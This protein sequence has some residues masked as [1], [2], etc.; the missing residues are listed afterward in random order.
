MVFLRAFLR[1]IVL[2]VIILAIA[3]WTFA[4][5]LQMTLLNRQ[6]VKVWGEQSGAYGKLVDTLE[7]RQVDATG[8]VSG[9]M[10]RQA[11]GTTF[12]PDYVQEQAEM[13]VDATYDWIDGDASQIAYTIPLHERQNDFIENLSQVLKERVQSLPQCS[14]S[15]SM[16]VECIPRAYTVESYARSVAEQ[17]ADDSDLFEEPLTSGDMR[18]VDAV[19][20]LPTLENASA[21]GVWA[22]PIVIVLGG[23]VYVALSRQWR[24]GIA[25]LGK[26][27]V[28]SSLTLV[29]V[30]LLG[31]VFGGSLR[32]GARLFGGSDETLIATVVEPILQQAISSIGMWL[33][34]AAGSVVVVG[35]ILW[36]VGYVLQRRGGGIS[37]NISAPAPAPSQRLD[38]H[39][40]QIQQSRQDGQ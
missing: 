8:L 1:G 3:L 33:T 17:T 26:R 24:A 21:M 19:A 9:D 22:L 30:G 16:N 14:G 29:V 25:N 40:Q 35:V 6:T 11:I 4:T 32:L 7:I 28:F 2:L 27:F 31:W 10:L 12:P 13:I 20:V 38:N 39:K 15:L 34:I 18:P 23:V 36:I 37:S 5:T